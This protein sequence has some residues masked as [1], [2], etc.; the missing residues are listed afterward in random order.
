[1]RGMW[2]VGQGNGKPKLTYIEK[3]IIILIFS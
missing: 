3:Y 2:T 1:M